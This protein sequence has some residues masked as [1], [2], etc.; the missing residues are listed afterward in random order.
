MRIENNKTIVIFPY[1]Q[2]KLQRFRDYT[3]SAC[4]ALRKQLRKF[5][6]I[7]QFEK[8]RCFTFAILQCCKSSE[9]GFTQVDR[10]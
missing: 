5:L 3:S 9:I 4:C 1:L 8:T 6:A 2:A 7:I 10:A